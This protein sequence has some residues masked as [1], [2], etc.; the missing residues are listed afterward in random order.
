MLPVYKNKR[1]EVEACL[2]IYFGPLLF[3]YFFS[4]IKGAATI[5]LQPL[6]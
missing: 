1:T 3:V 4:E 6:L 5:G 2:R